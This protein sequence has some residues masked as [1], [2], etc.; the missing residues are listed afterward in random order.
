MSRNLYIIASILILCGFIGI[1]IVEYNSG[2][3]DNQPNEW[4]A[5]RDSLINGANDTTI[6]NLSGIGIPDWLGA[7][8]AKG[9]EQRKS[10]ARKMVDV[11]S[12]LGSSKKRMDTLKNEL[13]KKESPHFINAR[14]KYEEEKNINATLNDKKIKL[15]IKTG[16]KYFF[17]FLSGSYLCIILISLTASIGIRR[18]SKF[19]LPTCP[20]K[21][22]LKNYFWIFVF[23]IFLVQVLVSFYTSV[24]ETDK[25][26][27][28]PIS[29][30]VSLSAWMIEKV[31]C[32]GLSMIMAIP[33]NMLWY[34]SCKTFIP[35]VSPS[36][37]KG[38]NG[39]FAVEKYVNFLQICTLS[40][41][42]LFALPTI[43]LIRWA[44]AQQ[45]GFEKTYLLLVLGGA[46][47]YLL[48]IGKMIRNALELRRRY[49]KS[50][51]L[52]FD[53]W[54]AVAEAKV[55]PDPTIDF[56][57][58]SWWKLPLSFAGIIGTIWALL[59]FTGVSKIIL[60]ALG[61]G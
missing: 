34:Y 41:F 47:I 37:L 57:G 8:K 53:S 30:F 14:E 28:L 48:L 39:K 15:E 43:I 36:L 11:A 54:K 44:A 5:V 2:L 46:L 26:M 59:E 33:I 10:W 50:I 4:I 27:I 7:I 25:L 20:D 35:E 18:M 23:Y 60:K 61:T 51:E 52:S 3:W 22:P 21:S 42:V 40:L 58:E 12:D 17:G 13:D 9:I 24:W 49:E 1:F 31:S 19:Y 32:F 45:A 16:K 56:I 29:F 38:A 6:D 55:L